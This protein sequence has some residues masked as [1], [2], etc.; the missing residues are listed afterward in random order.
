[1]ATNTTELQLYKKDPAADGATNFDVK[2]MMNDNWDK[3]D[4]RALLERAHRESTNNPHNTTAAQVGAYT[5][6]EADTMAQGKADAVQTNLSQHTANKSNPHA[7][8]AAQVGAY[9]KTEAD[10]MAQDKADAAA[11]TVQTNLTN[12]IGTGGTAHANAV[13][14]GAAGFITG[15]DK[16][17]LDGVAANANNYSHPIGDGNQHVP[18]TGTTNNG[19][20]LKA[21]S[22]A[23][24][25]AWGT[26]N[27]SEVGSKPTTLAGYGIADAAP[28]SHVTDKSNPHA[29]TA[30]QVGA[31][32]KTES[33]TNFAPK[34]HVGAGGTAHANAVSNGAAGFMTGADKAKLDGIAASANNYV[35][36]TTSGNKHIPA[37]G[38]ANQFLEWSADGTAVWSTVAASQVIEDAS[39]RFVT[40]TEKATWNGMVS[41]TGDGAIDGSLTVNGEFTAPQNP[42]YRYRAGSGVVTLPQNSDYKL[43]FN[44]AGS[45]IVNGVFTAPSTGRY[46][47]NLTAYMNVQANQNTQIKFIYNGSNLY[48][49]ARYANT[50]SGTVDHVFPVC[51]NYNFNAGDT[52]QFNVY[53]TSASSSLNLDNTVLTIVKVG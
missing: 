5:K 17:K 7:V 53:A 1:M 6:L 30:A 47:I 23:G 42:Y 15:A 45:D 37:G 48:I 33:D 3:L 44:L 26:V 51:I 34:S 13:A 24:S 52:L 16:A 46:Q 10:T 28:S 12:H 9:T 29:V 14:N 4:A 20:V 21:G 18:A 50:G 27:F 22:T 35:H 41:K 38:A 8:T 39:N 25:A 11:G 49:L 32:T 31:Y 36:P 19:K 2:T 43:P 40:D